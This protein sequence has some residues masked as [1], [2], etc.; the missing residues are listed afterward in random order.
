M[1]EVLIIDRSLSEIQAVAESM[2][3]G[4]ATTKLIMAFTTGWKCQN[5]SNFTKA[6][7]CYK[8]IM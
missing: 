3:V 4:S 6:K 5:P 7:K 1:I 8:I 2:F